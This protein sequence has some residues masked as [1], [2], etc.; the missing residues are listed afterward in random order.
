M[1]PLINKLIANL[2]AATNSEIK[3]QLKAHWREFPEIKHLE[4]D[5]LTMSTRKT[6]PLSKI[7]E[8]M[9]KN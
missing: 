9:T 5:N 8:I 4:E 6:P 3:L 2:P 7:L 1:N